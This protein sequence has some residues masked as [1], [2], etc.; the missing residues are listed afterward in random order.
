MSSL[1]IA[2]KKLVFIRSKRDHGGDRSISSTQYEGVVL[3]RFRE[4]EYVG[5]EWRSVDKYLVE[6]DGGI[7]ESFSPL[8]AKQI[9][10]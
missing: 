6:L 1:P 5:G 7:L 4:L 3:D 2:G 8:E 10:R 9:I